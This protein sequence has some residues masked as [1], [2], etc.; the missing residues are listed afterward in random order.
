MP[1][2]PLTNDKRV[3]SGFHYKKKRAWRQTALVS[4]HKELNETVHHPAG[5]PGLNCWKHSFQLFQFK[6][7]P[8]VWTHPYTVFLCLVFYRLYAKSLSFSHSWRVRVSFRCRRFVMSPLLKITRSPQARPRM[9]RLQMTD[10]HT[11]CTGLEFKPLSKLRYSSCR[12][13]HLSSSSLQWT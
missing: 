2:W 10:G 5:A 13:L 6:K 9:L 11:S 7:A 1:F 12:C 3:A 8:K 4:E